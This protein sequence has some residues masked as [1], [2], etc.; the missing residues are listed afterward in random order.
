MPV[1]Q[2]PSKSRITK[3][4]NAIRDG[5]ETEEDLNIVDLWRLSH[6]PVLNTFQSLLRSKARGHDIIVAQRH[7]RKNTIFDKLKRMPRMNLSRMDDV[8]GCRLIFR[9]IASLNNF[10][11]DMHAATFK[12][13]LVNDPG[14]YDYIDAPKSTGYRGIHDVYSYD[15]NSSSGEYLKGLRLEIQYRTRVQHA[16]ATANEVIGNITDS[17]P[18]FQRGNR[19][20]EYFMALASEMLARVHEGL[21]SCFP[22]MDNGKLVRTFIELD[23]DLEILRKLKNANPERSSVKNYD[24]YILIFGEKLEVRP[25][26]YESEALHH[27]FQMER[28]YPSLDIVLVRTKDRKELKFAFK[29][30]FKDASEFLDLIE[31]CVTSLSGAKIQNV[32][33]TAIQGLGWD[34][35]SYQQ[36]A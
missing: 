36:R 15:V 3:A 31:K 22:E 23:A 18:K 25:F 21:F 9:N 35:G 34:S 16:W 6:G 11:K 17:E 32:H 1:N 20:I 4:G 24:N 26:R 30:Y 7:K 19:Q 13:S 14:K 27:L 29:N 12:H 5:I 28:E 10:R 8:A 2:L 33:P